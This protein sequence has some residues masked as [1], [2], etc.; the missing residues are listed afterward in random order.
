MVALAWLINL[1]IMTLRLPAATPGRTSAAPPSQGQ[2]SQM[3]SSFQCDGATTSIIC[4]FYVLLEFQTNR[5]KKL[6]RKL[7]I[8]RK[9][10]ESATDVTKCSGVLMNKQKKVQG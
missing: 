10:K 2:P 4:L 3:G 9:K 6:G 5:E 1:T 7:T 8:G